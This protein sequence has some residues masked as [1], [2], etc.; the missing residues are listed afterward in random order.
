M[1]TA[2]APASIMD[3]IRNRR[4]VRAYAPTP[5]TREEVM[6][7]LRAATWAPTAMHEE[8]WA[9]AVIQDRALLRRLS[10]R[11]KA[12]FQDD[13]QRQA[14]PALAGRRSTF[15]DPAFNLFYDAG[16]LIVIY[17][18]PL[19]HYVAADCWLAAE[20]LMLAAWAQGLGT[21]VI[22]LAIPVLDEAPVKAELGIPGDLTAV[23]ALIV[24]T[25]RGETPAPPRR[26]PQVVAWR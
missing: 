20:N 11:G 12:R 18:K 17:G 13:A 9:F 7:L 24:G 6:G 4:S 22:G 21:C 14:R 25:P 8:P 1:I 10:D 26:E 2:A 16:T 23:V 15:A 19:G 5:V 3:A